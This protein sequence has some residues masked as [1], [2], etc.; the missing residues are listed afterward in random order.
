MNFSLSKDDLAQVLKLSAVLGLPNIAVKG[1][2]SKITI[3]AMDVKNQDSDVFSVE[4][5]ETSSEFQFIFVTE[6]LK[7]IPGTY[8]V[9]ISSKGISHFK[10][11]SEPLEY[12]IA[13]EAGSSYKE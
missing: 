4:V 10:H 5:G 11:S 6:N 3:T 8:N 12:W 13:T 1:N 7:M 2:R 9:S